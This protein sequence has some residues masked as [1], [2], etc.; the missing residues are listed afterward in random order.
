MQNK[1]FYSKATESKKNLMDILKE[2]FPDSKGHKYKNEID[3]IYQIVLGCNAR[4]YREAHE[5]NQKTSV[6]NGLSLRQLY[7]ISV[8]YD[9]DSIILYDSMTDYLKRKEYLTEYYNKI[10]MIKAS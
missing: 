1:Y 6:I 7:D 10:K 3:M 2:V 4:K 5:L 9:M 8:I